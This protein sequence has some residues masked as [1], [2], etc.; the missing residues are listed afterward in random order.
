MPFAWTVANSVKSKRDRYAKDGVI[1]CVGAG[2]MNRRDSVRI[3][4]LGA[5]EAAEANGWPMRTIGWVVASTPP[6]LRRRPARRRRS[7]AT[8]VI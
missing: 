6:P 2:Q 1:R 3:V 4:A 5:A 8:A 7:R